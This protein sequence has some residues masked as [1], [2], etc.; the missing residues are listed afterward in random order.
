MP[1]VPVY[2]EPDLRVNKVN[3]PIILFSDISLHYFSLLGLSGAL[4]DRFNTD[5]F[6]WHDA[7]DISK[8]YNLEEYA[9]LVAKQLMQYF[10][11]HTVLPLAGFSF[12]GVLATEV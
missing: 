2:P 5:C 1:P 7:D 11:H 6:I 3:P 8:P 10:G 9:K 4:A 12:G